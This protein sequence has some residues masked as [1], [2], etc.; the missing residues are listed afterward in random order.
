M[1]LALIYDQ[2]VRICVFSGAKDGNWEDLETEFTDIVDALEQHNKEIT[3]QLMEK[4]THCFVE[5]IRNQ[6]TF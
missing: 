1:F 6:L 3:A 4:H 5:H 2:A